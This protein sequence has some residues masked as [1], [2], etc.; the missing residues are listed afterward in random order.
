[1]V[2]KYFLNFKILNFEL[3]FPAFTWDFFSRLGNFLASCGS[4]FY[5]F[6]L[7]MQGSCKQ[8]ESPDF[9]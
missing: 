4:I 6:L 8:E 1:M 9:V 2:C 7:T 3:K 5:L